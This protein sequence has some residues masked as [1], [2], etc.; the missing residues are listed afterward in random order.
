[1]PFL[2]HLEE[3]RWR[4]IKCI[5]AVLVLTLVSYF[6]SGQML[7][8]L[9]RPFPA[10]RK[11]I[12]LSPTEGFMIRIKLSLFG[13]IIFGL[14]VIFYQ[15]WQF[16]AP[17]LLPHEKRYVP[18]IIIISTINFVIG[19]LFAYFV[20]VPIGLNFLLGFE[21]PDVEAAI[22]IKDYLGFVTN[23]MLAFGIVFEL[24]VLS[25]ILAR[26]GILTPEFMSRYRRYSIVLVFVVAAILTPPDVFSQILL[27]MPLIVLY[28]ISIIVARLAR[29][30]PREKVAPD[31]EREREAS[32]AEAAKEPTTEPEYGD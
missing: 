22:R 18:H 20:I 2:D 11:L 32:S 16:I 3:L 26:I 23:L 5:A 21:T 29:R 13:G 31:E 4:L 6:F 7:S 9:T 1:M 17:G 15:M 8:F 28:E 24:P 10:G 27:A 19:A 30:R 25:F 14:P 12:F